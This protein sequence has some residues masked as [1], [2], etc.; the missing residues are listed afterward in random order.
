MICIA[1]FNVQVT[2]VIEPFGMGAILPLSAGSKFGMPR[3]KLKREIG[4]KE[5]AFQT[6]PTALKH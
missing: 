6:A 2:S 4:V 5:G 1:F 3:G